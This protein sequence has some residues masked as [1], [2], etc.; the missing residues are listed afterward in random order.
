MIFSLAGDFC[1]PDDFSSSFLASFFV[2]G[3]APFGNKERCVL[4]M[5]EPI[6]ERL[7]DSRDPRIL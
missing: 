7:D 3:L 5:A 1:F 2:L 6:D 4:D